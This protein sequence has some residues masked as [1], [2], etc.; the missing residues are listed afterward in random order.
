MFI[1]E[2]RVQI[3]DEH[4]PR[5]PD[6]LFIARRTSQEQHRLDRHPRRPGLGGLLL[7]FIDPARP[8]GFMELWG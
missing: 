4:D 3:G 8:L 6:P 5:K 7:P 1:R 2:I